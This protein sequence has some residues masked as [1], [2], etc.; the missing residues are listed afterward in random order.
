MLMCINSCQW[1]TG[2]Y[3]A[4]VKSEFQQG[5]VTDLDWNKNQDS[6]DSF[7]PRGYYKPAPVGG[8]NFNTLE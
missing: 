4:D 1:S 8:Y 5:W 7:F 6:T 3:F 2:T